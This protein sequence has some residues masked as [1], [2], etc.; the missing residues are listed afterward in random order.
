MGEKDRKKSD[1]E[2]EREIGITFSLAREHI[3]RAVEER[4]PHKEK[5]AHDFGS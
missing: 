3:H 4:A 2:G 1:R 5:A